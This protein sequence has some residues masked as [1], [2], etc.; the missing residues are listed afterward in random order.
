MNQDTASCNAGRVLVITPVFN[1]W[2]SARELL[3]HLDVALHSSNL[4]ADV[5]MV[6]DGSSQPL[7]ADLRSGEH[8]AI[9]KIDLLELT[10][11]LGHQRAIAVG[12]VHAATHTDADIMVVMDCD[13]EDA[14]ADVPL[15]VRRLQA[16]SQNDVVFAGRYRRSESFLFRCGYFAYRMMHL[17]LTGI[18]I[19]F[20]NFS[21]IRSAAVR[22][23]IFQDALWNHYAAAVVRSR[24]AYTT[25]PTVRGTRFEGKSKQSVLH[26]MIHGFSALSVF[27]GIVSCRLF[28]LMTLLFTTAGAGAVYMLACRQISLPAL[29]VVGIA[30]LS[31]L[32]SFLLNV[33][34][35]VALRST[36]AFVPARDASV[37]I[38]DV[39]TIK[40]GIG[41][42]CN[43]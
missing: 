5:L 39:L 38:R 22:Q 4:Q 6:N 29:L 41:S 21:A 11:N 32:V 33:I 10:C 35:L 24:I 13:G 25:I 26:L 36:P 17:L 23:L 16:Q 14:P 40:S 37:F 28:T 7:P 43:T 2:L 27:S 34:A 3:T 18:R 15:L 31:L 1:D 42:V 8:K 20:G 19:R 30:G 9:G 12:L